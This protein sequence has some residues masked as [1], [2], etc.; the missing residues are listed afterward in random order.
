MNNPG[1]ITSFISDELEQIIQDHRSNNYDKA[2]ALSVLFE[3]VCEWLSEDAGIQFI[4]LFPRLSYIHTKFNL[5]EIL[6]L[7][8]HHIRKSLEVGLHEISDLQQ[9][10]DLLQQYLT[11]LKLFLE[12]TEFDDERL[13]SLIG[14]TN[15]TDPATKKGFAHLMEGLIT[16]FDFE[17]NVF[18]F[19][20]DIHPFKNHTVRYD[21]LEKNERFT[22]NLVAASKIFKLPLPVNLIDVDLLS[23]EDL[24]P[25]AFV[26]SPDY[27]VDVTTIASI[28][29]DRSASPWLYVM[30]KYKAQKSSPA[31][32]V[33]NAVNFFLDRLIKDPDLEMSSMY[34]DLFAMDTMA[35]VLFD[36]Q[37]VDEIIG[38][39]QTHFD[40]LKRVIG[41]DFPSKGIQNGRI[42]LEPTFYCRDYGIQGRLDLFHVDDERTRA[43]IIELKSTK[44]FK[45]NKYGI[46]S[47]HYI[48]T[49][50]YEMIIQS[51]YKGSIKLTNY[52]LYSVLP[53]ENLKP[54][55]GMKELRY[56]ILKTRNEIVTI[57]YGLANDSALAGKV[58]SFLTTAH[59]PEVRGFLQQDLSQFENIYASLDE[60]EKLYL[61]RFSHFIAK[62]HLLAKTGEH[63]VDNANGLSALWLESLE[64]KT[65][66]FGIFNHLQIVK[67]DSDEQFPVIVLKKTKATASLA[68]FRQGDIGVLYP[69]QHNRR[70]VL[71]HEIFK[72]TILEVNDKEITVRMRHP[73][74]NQHLFKTTKF[75]NV[76]VD[77]LDSSFRHMY[78]NL[79]EWAGADAKVRLLLTGRQKP[80]FNPQETMLEMDDQLT[81]QQKMIVRK[82][83]ET[84]DYL[85]LWG[86]PGTGKTS[87]IIK[88]AAHHLYKMSDERVIY[89]AYTNRAVDEICDA[90]SEAGLKDQFI[91]IGSRYSV[92]EAYVSNLL[93]EQI[94][95]LSNRAQIRTLLE[96][97]KIYVSTVASLQSKQELFGLVTFKTAIVDEA[98]QILEPQLI[99]L[100][101]R[102][103]R[104]VLIGDHKQLP[105]VVTQKQN[106]TRISDDVLSKEGITSTAMSFFERLYRQCVSNG[107]NHAYEILS[108]QGRMHQELM[109]F[110][111]TYF[112]ENKLHLVPNVN[113]LT[114]VLPD[115][116]APLMASRLVYIPS[117][118]DNSWQWKINK[119]EA[120]IIVEA[121]IAFYEYYSEYHLEWREDTLG[122]IVPYKAQIAMVK[123][124]LGDKVPDVTIDT[125][126]RY[127]G[128]ARDIIIYGVCTNRQRQMEMIVSKNEEG[129][130]RK[131][132]VAVTRARDRLVLVGNETILKS[133]ANY[134]QLM[135]ICTKIE[136][137]KISV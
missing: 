48:Q 2:K 54:A 27:L 75:W 41:K 135:E 12:N 40:N 113:R 122:I 32:M 38:K 110:P 51:T 60:F 74:L 108:Q 102:F 94:K 86:P 30:D 42:Y 118:T 22:K 35:W 47:S 99:G 14:H 115:E 5:P 78:R 44:P 16:S 7:A 83:L 56:E 1:D 89:M 36:D 121:S 131:L 57:E 76:E 96:Q 59:L 128:G 52:I 82:I 18:Q 70:Q 31:L 106:Y 73:Q 46:S 119:Y 91:R 114:K 123:N 39:L 92:G 77:V 58:F 105:A 87:V 93:D 125:V 98:S 120:A 65:E 72:C 33:G 109:K 124:L 10:N 55:F 26:I 95:D 20:H 50:L 126:E 80:D 53:E 67:N 21:V 97:C 104:F 134:A 3:R 64:E 68:N 127:Q 90:L 136:S 6:H 117:P 4:S 85:L 11:G 61:Q 13:R 45:P 101:T 34:Q 100:L 23:N 24:V 137:D 29:G 17:R 62:E 130:D 107:W 111:A 84:R 69:H 132:N 129:L 8:G 79:Y 15:E 28:Q 71:H 19:T 66:R 116:K 63:G 49:M 133:D 81:P 37:T 112:Y 9:Y 25:S 103:Q 43:E 88:N